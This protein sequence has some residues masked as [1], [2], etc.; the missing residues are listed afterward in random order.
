MAH[1]NSTVFYIDGAWVAPQGV[2]RIDVINP[3]TEQAVATLA[4]GN[5]TDVDHAVAAAK[6]AFAAF[7]VTSRD[8]RLSLLTKIAA[9]MRARFDDLAEA[10]TAEMG[11]PHT[12]AREGQVASG[13]EHIDQMIHVLKTFSFETQAGT[14]RIVKEAAGVCGLITPWNWPLNQIA[15]KVAPALAAGCTMVLKPSEIAPLSAI[16]FAEIL[17]EAGVPKGVFN[18]VHGDGP[19]VGHAMAVHPD[20]DVMSF[21]GSTRAGVQVARDS[22]ETV[23]RVLQ[24]LGGNSANIILDDAD[25]DSAIINGIAGCYLNS[26]QSCDSPARMLVPH[27]AMDKAIELAR[28]AALAYCVGDPRD[29][30]IHLGPVVSEV[31]FNKIQNFIEIGIC[32]GAELVTGGLGRPAP[33]HTGY[34][35]QPTVFARVTPEMTIARNEIFGPVLSIIGYSDVDEAVRIANDTEYGLAG[36]VQSGDIHRARSIARRLRAGT[37]QINFPPADYLAPFGGYKR[38]GNGREYGAYGLHDYLEFKSII[39]FG[40]ED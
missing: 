29:A 30:A 33:L 15:C 1:W 24:E 23:K 26:G 20:I 31:H 22:A 39:G 32:E 11:A 4:L 8:E 3:A 25:L 16:V 5:A 14:T 34:Y 28:K 19:T 13:L 36:Y 9:L 7:S 38:S 27:A 37:V 21:T 40:G 35:V 6:R 2:Q 12:F 10:M 18:L 17:H